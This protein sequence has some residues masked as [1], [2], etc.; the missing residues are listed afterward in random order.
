MFWSSM[1]KKNRVISNEI[2]SVVIVLQNIEQNTEY[3][4][5]QNE[6][7]NFPGCSKNELSIDKL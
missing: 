6:R 7:N 3:H 1:K 5:K 2:S 4:I